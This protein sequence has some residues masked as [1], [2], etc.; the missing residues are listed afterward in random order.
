MIL[1]RKLQTTNCVRLIVHNAS[2]LNC[3]FPL[4]FGE[5]TDF[6]SDFS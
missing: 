3:T 4:K 6:G 2:N 5:G 1:Y